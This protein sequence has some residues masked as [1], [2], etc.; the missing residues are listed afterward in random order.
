ME[1]VPQNTVRRIERAEVRVSPG[2]LGY[3]ER[4]R[5]AIEANWR[6]EVMAKPALF[7][8]EVYLAPQAMLESGVLRADFQR[9]G[10]SMLMYW[11]RD[12]EPVRPWHIF[13]VGVI[14]SREGHL[15]AARMGA[16]TAGAGRVYFPSGSIDDNDLVGDRVDYD[17]NIRREVMEET[18]LDLAEARAEPGFS[19]VTGNRS[20]ALFRRHFFDAPARELLAH[21]EAHLAAE[22]APELAGLLSVTGAGQMGEATPSYVRAFADWHFDC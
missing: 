18:G 12:P 6:R 10:F 1:R 5:A 7:D 15:I 11:R 16:G 4:H 17:G 2:P 21:A 20:I 13:A 3:T 19:L 22:T 14:V 9:T 8:G